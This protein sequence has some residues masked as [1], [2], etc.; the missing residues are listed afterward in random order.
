MKIAV[1]GLGYVGLPL[2]V[3]DRRGRARGHRLRRHAAKVDEL[4]AGELHP[5]CR[6][7][8]RG[9]AG[10]ARRLRRHHRLRAPRRLRRDHHLRADAAQQ[11]RE[12][13]LSLRRA[14]RRDAAGRRT[15]APASSSCSKARPTPA[16]REESS[17]PSSRPARPDGRRRL[18]PGL[19]SR[20]RRSRATPTT[21]RKNTPKVVGGVTPACTRAGARRSTAASST[22]W[23][24]S[25]R[26]AA[27]EM[28]KLLENMFRCVNIALVNELAMLCD[29]MGIDVWEVIDAAATKPFGFMPFYPGPGA[30]RALH[31]DRSVLP[32][33]EGARVRASTRSSSSWPARSTSTCRTTWST[34][35]IDAL[36]ARGKRL[37]GARVLVL[38]VAYK[39]RHRRH[40]RSRRRS[41]SSPSCA[42]T[43]PRS[44]T[45][46]RTC[47]EIPKV[48]KHDFDLKSIAARRS[49][50]FGPCDAALIITDHS[51]STTSGSRP[52]RRSSS[53]PGTR[54]RKVRA[55]S[56]WIVR[57]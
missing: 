31:P 30:R 57:G 52:T 3:R 35:L 37:N 47:P 22:A 24:R 25:P 56:V 7:R 46:I 53:T 12:P 44:S 4:N 42:N 14:T 33:V 18:L 43:G 21:R 11:N 38:G 17:C 34:K 41:R 28:T 1:I 5:R 40:A 8:R 27:A 39:A 50:S 29:R 54:R 15:C 10:R 9:R 36:N 16:R 20:A 32:D 51:A 45:T 49:S 48:R 55:G 13:D 6:I 26:H 23:C 2:A 19:L